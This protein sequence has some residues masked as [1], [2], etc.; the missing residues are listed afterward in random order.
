MSQPVLHP[1]PEE[2]RIESLRSQKC[3]P[4]SI[5]L[6]I[7]PTLERRRCRFVY[8]VNHWLF[9]VTALAQPVQQAMFVSTEA[10]RSVVVA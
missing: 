2:L 3:V 5:P 10:P 1:S 8:L 7:P 9:G 4:R 6:P